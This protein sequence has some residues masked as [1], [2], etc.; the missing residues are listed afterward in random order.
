MPEIVAVTGADGFLGK[1]LVR[2]LSEQSCD[3]IPITRDNGF[4]VCENNSLN[5]VPHFDSLIHLAAR[6]FVPSSFE[7]PRDFFYDN[8]ISTLNILELCR[9]YGSR[10]VFAS[11]AVE[12][13]VRTMLRR[14]RLSS[15]FMR[16]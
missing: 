9:R 7:H 1:H 13:F 15:P 16:G 11:S 3:I 4:D 14:R 2:Q 12:V 5:N 8:I 10:M 6:S